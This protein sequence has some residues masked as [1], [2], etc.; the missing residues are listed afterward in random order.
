MPKQMIEIENLEDKDAI[1]SESSERDNCA[2]RI[3]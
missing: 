3:S 1:E 2:K